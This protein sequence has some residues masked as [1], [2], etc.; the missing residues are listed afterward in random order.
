MEVRPKWLKEDPSVEELNP[1]DH[2]GFCRNRLMCPA[3]GGIAV[4]IAQRYGE[5]ELPDGTL[6][7]SEVRDPA[8]LSVMLGVAKL[9]KGWAEAVVG[10]A[11]AFVIEE[12]NELPGWK[13]R[14]MGVT[15]S[16]T[17]QEAFAVLTKQFGISEVDLQKAA[18]YN[19]PL[20]RSMVREAAGRGKK[21]AAEQQFLEL[22][23]EVGVLKSSAPRYS[24]TPAQK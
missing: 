11:T 6:H 14:F 3:V 2:C 18:Q 17:D 19:L 9:V 24:L 16:I 23:E 5:M 13:S 4:N 1:N 10:H 7:S 15:R 21:T 20:V 8:K 12:G 22:G